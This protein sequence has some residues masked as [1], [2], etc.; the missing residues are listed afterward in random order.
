MSTSIIFDHLFT[1]EGVDQDGKKF[2]RVSRINAI[3]T[4]P[5]LNCI[6]DLPVEVYSLSPNQKFTLALSTSLSNQ[7]GQDVSS[8][9]WRPGMQ[10]QGLAEDYEYV[11]FGKIYKFDEEKQEVAYVYFYSILCIVMFKYFHSTAYISFGGLLLA[12]TGH[13]K[14]LSKLSVGDDIYLLI[15][16]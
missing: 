11:C 3:S 14:Y 2:D 16:K 10:N 15:R 7:S 9:G 12:I 1:V 6:I 5:S 4:T 13:V 8:Q